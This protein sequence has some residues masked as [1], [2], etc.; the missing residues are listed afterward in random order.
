MNE[1]AS[2]NLCAQ[3]QHRNRAM[4]LAFVAVLL[5]GTMVIPAFATGATGGA[6][7]EIVTGVSSGM[8]K[9][10]TLFQALLAPIAVVLVVWNV[11][12]AL[13]FGEKGMEGAKKGIIIILGIVAVV[14]LAPLIVATVQGWFSNASNGTT[15]TVFNP[16]WQNPGNP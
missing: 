6:E 4:A 8:Y 10:Y 1:I 3:K 12:K 11:F 5:V 13:F 15:S 16:V 14:Y 2:C 7:Q 9:L